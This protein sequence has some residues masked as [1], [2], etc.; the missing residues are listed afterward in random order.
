MADPLL[1]L[2][3]AD[4]TTWSL[5]AK[6]VRRRNERLFSQLTD[7]VAADMR[8]RHGGLVTFVWSALSTW[9]IPRSLTS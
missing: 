6:V 7:R 5:S 1:L 9:R 8:R 2:Y 4:W 3:R